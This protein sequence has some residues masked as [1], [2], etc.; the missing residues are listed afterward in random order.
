MK[1]K[2]QCDLICP[3]LPKVLLRLSDAPRPDVRYRIVN[4]CVNG[5]PVARRARRECSGVMEQRA[6]QPDQAKARSL[7]AV[8]R[9]RSRPE[10]R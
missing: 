1:W 4:D 2:G 3:D 6:E 9:R 7:T 5:A 10:R 8:K